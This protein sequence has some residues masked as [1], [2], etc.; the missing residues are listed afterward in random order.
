MMHDRLLCGSRKPTARW[1]DDR[2]AH[3]LRTS[4]S[5]WRPGLIVTTR[6]IA[7]RVSGATTGC[8]TAAGTLKVLGPYKM[9][10]GGNWEIRYGCGA[11]RLRNS[12]MAVAFAVTRRMTSHVHSHLFDTGAG[13]GLQRT[14]RNKF[15]NVGNHPIAA[16]YADS[17]HAGPSRAY[18]SKLSLVTQIVFTFHQ[19]MHTFQ[20]FVWSMF[21]TL[22][23]YTLQ[24]NML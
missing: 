4:T 15:E 14:S 20:F 9:I 10:R 22:N 2:S 6:N 18:S 19:I 11:L 13:K 12:L 23:R 8:E 1:S 21:Y 3:S 17:D 7:A 5:D 16:A 24:L